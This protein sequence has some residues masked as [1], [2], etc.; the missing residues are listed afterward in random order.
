MFKK[1]KFES[2]VGS[3]G[4]FFYMRSLLFKNCN[5]ITKKAKSWSYI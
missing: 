4:S 5:N 1:A 2:K 3:I